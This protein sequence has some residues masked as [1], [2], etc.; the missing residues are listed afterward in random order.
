VRKGEST[1][2]FSGNTARQ[3]KGRK[4]KKST[5]VSHKEAQKAQ[6]SAEPIELFVLLFG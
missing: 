1:G 5:H 3:D 6:K 2:T 4:L